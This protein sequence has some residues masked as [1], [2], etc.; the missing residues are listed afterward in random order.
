MHCSPFA[1]SFL[2]SSFLAAIVNKYFLSICCAPG[3]LQ[4]YYDNS[5]RQSPGTNAL[6]HLADPSPTTGKRSPTT[7]AY[8][9]QLV[10]GYLPFKRSSGPG[11]RVR[12]R[13]RTSTRPPAPFPETRPNSASNASARTRTR[14]SPA[15]RPLRSPPP[16]PVPSGRA[17]LAV[18][19][20]AALLV[21][22]VRALH[23]EAHP[24]P[25]PPPGAQPTRSL[26]SRPRAP[27][28]GNL[29][30][31]PGRFELPPRRQGSPRPDQPRAGRRPF[32][33]QPI[34]RPFSSQLRPGDPC[35]SGQWNRPTTFS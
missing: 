3:M 32:Y 25:P 34:G 31:G 7:L 19:Q 16:L 8:G 23:G 30:S 15:C 26:P 6:A 33:S 10:P 4:G 35:S 13:A 11:I 27:R 2:L 21:A 18:P 12:G 24:R 9:A 5:R 22:Q 14:P 17:G 29:S 20:L 1:A 28:P